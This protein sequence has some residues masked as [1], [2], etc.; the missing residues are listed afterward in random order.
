MIIIESLHLSY[1]ETSVINNLN[2]NIET[3]TV[4]GLVGLNGSGKTT[5]LSSMYGL[6]SVERGSMSFNG[7]PLRRSMIGY[8]ETGNFFYSRITG[9]EYLELFKVR[10]PSFRI[11]DWNGLFELPLRNLIES[12]STGMKKKLAFLGII[13]MDKPILILDEPF[14]G[15]DM[16]TTQT[17]KLIIMALKQRSKTIIITSHILES[18]TSICD[19]ISYLRDKSIKNT[20]G[21]DSFDEIE[22]TI[23]GAFNEVNSQKIKH[24]LG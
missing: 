16:E 24:L 20:F 3:G 14:N 22:T 12:Y 19:S 13:A 17:L 4:H 10:N 23:F 1:G 6:K 8:L 2:L 7:T 21:K 11:D 5:L 9:M 15:I 18:L